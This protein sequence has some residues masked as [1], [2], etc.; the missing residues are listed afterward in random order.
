[1]LRNAFAYV[2]RKGLKSLIILLVI[3]AMST[4]SLISL[5]IKDATNR[6]SEETFGNITNSFSMEINRQV[7]PG[8]PRGGGNVKGQDIKKISETKNID[9]FV[10]RINS[11]ADLVDF[12][13]IE[14]EETLANQSEERACF[15]AKN[16]EILLEACKTL[17]LFSQN[18][19]QIGQSNTHK[20][21]PRYHLH[22]PKH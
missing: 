4:L 20:H 2:T 22:G 13:I 10:K 3:L 1:M 21:L 8:T 15:S 12:S 14:T 17:Q 11:V 6:A 19:W 7:N 18:H 5:S 16:P 9:S